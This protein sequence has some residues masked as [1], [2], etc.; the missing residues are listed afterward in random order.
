MNLEQQRDL[1]YHHVT[2]I[3]YWKTKEAV[4]DKAIA[5]AWCAKYSAKNWREVWADAFFEWAD[6]TVP[7]HNFRFYYH[8]R[9]RYYETAYDYTCLAEKPKKEDEEKAAQLEIDVQLL[10]LQKAARKTEREQFSTAVGFA[11]SDL[12]T[13]AT[14][15]C[16]ELQLL[17]RFVAA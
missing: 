6:A 5:K 3:Y 4:G 2:A 17:P 7:E 12:T 10:M 9:L 16:L 8:Q 13:Y 11:C 1:L 15:R 14:Q